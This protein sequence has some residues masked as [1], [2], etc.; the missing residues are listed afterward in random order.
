MYNTADMRTV[1]AVNLKLSFQSTEIATNHITVATIMDIRVDRKN[2]KNTKEIMCIHRKVH[3][4]NKLMFC[5][6]L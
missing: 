4:C 1:K 2:K 3:N 5:I 6:F